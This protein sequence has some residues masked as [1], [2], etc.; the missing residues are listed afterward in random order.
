MILWLVTL[1]IQLFSVGKK[2]TMLCVPSGNFYIMIVFFLLLYSVRCLNTVC[3]FLIKSEFVYN[4]SVNLIQ[5]FKCARFL[6][7]DCLVTV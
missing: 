2:K 3:C 5:A 6:S 4:S 7:K 1:Y